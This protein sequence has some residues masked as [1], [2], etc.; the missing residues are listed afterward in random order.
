MLPG[1]QADLRRSLVPSKLAPDTRRGVFVPHASCR[2]KK[3]L[4]SPVH[5]SQAPRPA[6]EPRLFSIEPDM[7]HTV[8]FCCDLFCKDYVQVKVL[9]VRFSRCTPGVKCP[10]KT[11]FFSRNAAADIVVKGIDDDVVEPAGAAFRGSGLDQ[12][13][14]ADA[15]EHP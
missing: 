10:D 15:L 2:V 11:S 8:S 13:G 1:E 3:S 4:K 5:Q 14:Q 7:S 12:F 6:V 9:S